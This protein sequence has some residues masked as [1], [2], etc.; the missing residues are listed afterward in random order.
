MRNLIQ[1][2][3]MTLRKPSS[4]QKC[5][6][7][8]QWLDNADM[9]L[10]AKLEKNIPCGSRVMSIFT[11]Y[12]WTDGQIDSHSDYSADPRVV[13]FITLMHISLIFQ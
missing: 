13:Q 9:H 8:C 4:I 10:Y 12:Y 2:Y 6:Y 7:T 5:C 11:N 3:E 1:I